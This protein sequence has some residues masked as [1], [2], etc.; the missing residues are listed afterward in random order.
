MTSVPL[1]SISPPIWIS[2]IQPTQ[3]EEDEIKDYI[4]DSSERPIL[5]I[6]SNN[7]LISDPKI[8][9]VLQKLN[10][11]N[12]DVSVN[13]IV[14]PVSDIGDIDSFI[15]MQE[16]A[17]RFKV[18]AMD[19]ARI[20]GVIEE[21]WERA[22]TGKAKMEFYSHMDK[23][24]GRCGSSTHRYCQIYRTFKSE[25][26]DWLNNKIINMF[27]QENLYK[28]VQNKITTEQRQGIINSIIRDYSMSDLNVDTINKKLIQRISAA[29]CQILEDKIE[30]FTSRD[31]EYYVH[32]MNDS[33][34]KFKLTGEY[35]SSLSLFKN[36]LDEYL[37][38][39]PYQTDENLY[40]VLALFHKLEEIDLESSI[41]K[42]RWAVL[43][44][45]DSI[46]NTEVPIKIQQTS[47]EE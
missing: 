47:E 41:E 23:K 38:R 14:V 12:P 20:C 28:I 4:S 34:G 33:N 10:I 22:N 40:R 21:E 1:S 7:D 8:F 6:S 45:I 32:S 35:I 42:F 26:K 44:I 29:K 17:K 39:L 27:K 19:I 31:P 43:E 37:K 18:N 15:F 25:N 36:Q 11:P 16:T 13:V 9:Y 2:S 46:S 3:S 30:K 5:Q 24:L